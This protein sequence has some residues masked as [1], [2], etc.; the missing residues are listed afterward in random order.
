MK[1]H[2]LEKRARSRQVTFGELNARA[3]PIKLRDGVARLFAPY[4]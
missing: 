4:L 2:L 1:S 3:L